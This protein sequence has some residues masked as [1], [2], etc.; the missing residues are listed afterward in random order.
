MTPPL[1]IVYVERSAADLMF[2]ELWAAG[3]MMA[4]M[5]KEKNYIYIE[6]IMKIC[7]KGND[8]A[9]YHFV[10]DEFGEVV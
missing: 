10:H 1:H 4:L 7:R 5:R 9:I 8:C 6:D 3:H 2:A